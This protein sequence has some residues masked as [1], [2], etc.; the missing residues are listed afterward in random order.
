MKET[1]VKFDSVKDDKGNFTKYSSE[2][3]K[4]SK[5]AY[6]TAK[7]EYNKK[8]LALKKGTVFNSVKKFVK[9][10]RSR[11][12]EDFQYGFHVN[13]NGTLLTDEICK[14]LKKENFK[15]FL[16]FNPQ[17]GPSIDPVI[18]SGTCKITEVSGGLNLIVDA[19]EQ[20]GD[21]FKMSVFLEDMGE[22][23]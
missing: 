2:A 5:A 14:F 18:K 3:F 12:P 21:K 16:S 9:E 6:E 19:V 8:I 23:F 22:N 7:E 15:I 1:G 20:G 13:T 10:N 11:F 17:Q 4:N